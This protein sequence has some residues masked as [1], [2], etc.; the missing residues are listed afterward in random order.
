MFGG[1]FNEIAF[2]NAGGENIIDMAA[3]MSGGAQLYSR[4]IEG[5]ENVAGFNLVAFNSPDQSTATEYE[6]QYAMEMTFSAE[7]CGEAQMQSD[8]V[9]EYVFEATQM[10]GESSMTA[11]F[12]REMKLSS[13]MSGEAQFQANASRYHVDYIE[14]EGTFDPGDRIVIDS[15]NLKFTQNGQNVLFK[16]NGD[17]FDLNLGNNILTWTDS[18]TVRSVLMRITF[19]DRFV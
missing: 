15:K 6:L 13:G 5:D 2:N 7:M 3:A 1:E 9:R 14:F 19:Q 4:R 16:M 12:I 11:D 17:F 18:E 10:S 8:F